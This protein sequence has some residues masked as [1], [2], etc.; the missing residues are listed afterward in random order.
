MNQLYLSTVRNR[1]IAMY[2]PNFILGQII[3]AANQ[4]ADIDKYVCKQNELKINTCIY[5]LATGKFEGLKKELA[6][7]VLRGVSNE[8]FF[9]YGFDSDKT[10]I[11]Y[12]TSK[13][14]IPDAFVSTAFKNTILKLLMRGERERNFQVCFIIDLLLLIEK[15]RLINIV[16]M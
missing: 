12:S 3:I 1:G 15:K 8:I 10:A 7:I 6:F 13:Q 5:D 2:N 14:K 16:V 9:S 4:P 11:L